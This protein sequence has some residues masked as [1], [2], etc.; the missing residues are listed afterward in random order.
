MIIEELSFNTNSGAIMKILVD[1]DACPKAIKEILYKAATRLKIKTIFLANQP[2]RIPL[3]LFLEFRQVPAGFDVVDHKI[4]ELLEKNDL[5]ITADIPL[6]AAV[7]A[8]EGHALNPR[9]EFYHTENVQQ[10]LTMRNFMQSLRDTGEVFG[11]PAPLHTKNL[12]AFGN[13][14]DQFLTRMLKNES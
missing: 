2:M 1:A 9:G 11:G 12:Q 6:A 13:A 14:L 8:Q 10:K 5:V 7:I 4:L 3:S